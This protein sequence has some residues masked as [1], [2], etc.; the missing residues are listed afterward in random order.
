M[1][2]ELSPLPDNLPAGAP[3]EIILK[4]DT[5]GLFSVDAKDVTG[6][7]TVHMEVQVGNTMTDEEVAES[8]AYFDGIK[9][10]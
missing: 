7:R 6:G 8:K 3:I 4:I 9:L 1:S 2:D 5:Q 10:R